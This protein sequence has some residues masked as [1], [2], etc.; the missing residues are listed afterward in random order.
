MK[1][2]IYLKLIKKQEK[3]VSEIEET[4]QMRTKEADM[5]E[6][7]TIDMED[8]SHQDENHSLVLALKEQLAAAQTEL[9]DLREYENSSNDQLERGALVETEDAYF[10]VGPS[11]RR[12][13][14]EDKDV[15]SISDQSTVYKNNEGAKKGDELK[16]NNASFKILS[17]S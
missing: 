13:Q 6:N 11:V 4:I 14:Y 2:A 10:V 8:Y 12:I 15:I 17:I 3:I 16:T 1:K 5:E 7:E 9:D